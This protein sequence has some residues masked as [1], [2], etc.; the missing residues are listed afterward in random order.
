MSTMN[1][2]N[3]I[4]IISLS[5]VIFLGWLY[6]QND[7][8]KIKKML[9]EIEVSLL[10]NEKSS[11]PNI[12]KKVKKI[13]K[14]FYPTARVSIEK[15]PYP[16]VLLESRRRVEQTLLQGFH[17]SYKIKDFTSRIDSLKITPPKAFVKISLSA[18]AP[19]S[20]KIE[21]PL[22]I[23]LKKEKRRWFI[24]SIQSKDNF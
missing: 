5:A 2:K 8:K 6:F 4:L 18:Q 21:L 10:S 14:H 16:P 19:N 1:V 20:E 15:P 9:K 24:F 7:E 23:E 17:S 3:L 13:G 11:L 12:I 22:D